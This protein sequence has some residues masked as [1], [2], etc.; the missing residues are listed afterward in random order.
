MPSHRP[1]R[2]PHIAPYPPYAIRNVIVTGMVTTA[3]ATSWYASESAKGIAAIY[4]IIM[5]G[6]VKFLY[7]YMQHLSNLSS[8]FSAQFLELTL[9]QLHWR[10]GTCSMVP[11]LGRL[12]LGQLY[13]WLWLWSWHD[14]ATSARLGSQAFTL[15]L[16]ALAAT[17]QQPQWFGLQERSCW[18]SRATVR[19]W[20]DGYNRMYK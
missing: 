9:R 13:N 6:E 18:F 16:A 20:L 4:P 7:A 12:A 10:I 1:C 3:I 19:D 11:S 17:G 5:P 14:D 15:G 2:C 8:S